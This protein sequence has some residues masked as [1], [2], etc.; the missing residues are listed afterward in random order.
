MQFRADLS[1][2]TYER[3]SNNEASA[4]GTAVLAAY[5]VGLYPSIGDAVAS[6][7]RIKDCFVQIRRFM[8]PIVRS[9]SVY[10]ARKAY[11]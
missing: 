1:G 3:M 5:G 8:K 4:L 9:Y 10:W 2:R 7:V 11:I 6:M